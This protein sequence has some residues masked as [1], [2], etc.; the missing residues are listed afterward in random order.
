M[1]AAKALLSDQ[2]S[3]PPKKELDIK[4]AEMNDFQKD[5]NRMKEM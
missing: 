3:E 5:L 1:T 4:K 2:N